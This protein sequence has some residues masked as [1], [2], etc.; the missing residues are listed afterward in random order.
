MTAAPTPLRARIEAAEVVKPE[1]P[2]FSATPFT[3][4]NPATIPPR[5]W[6]YGR[7]LLGASVTAMVAPGGVGKSTFVAGMALAMVTGIE[8]HNRKVWLGAKRVW[9]WNLE[10]PLDELNRSIGAAMLHFGITETDIEGRLFVDTAMD[11]Q[12]L[13]TATML[14][15]EVNVIAPVYDAIVAAIRERNIDGLIIDP[16]VSSHK[17]DENSNTA[18]DAITKEWVRVAAATGCCIVLVHHTSKAGSGEVTAMSGRGAVAMINACRSVLVFNRMD[19]ADASKLGIEE[20]EMWRYFCVHDDKHNRAPAEKAEWFR[21]ESVGLGNGTTDLP[22][23]MMGVARPWSPPD[24]FENIS[25]DHLR[26]VQSI[27]SS[28]L[29]RDSSQSPEWAGFAV[30]KVL[31]LEIASDADKPRFERAADKRQAAQ[32]LSTWI[33]NGALKVEE[34]PHPETRKTVKFVKVGL[35]CVDG[36][37]PPRAGGAEQGGAPARKNCSTTTTPPKGWVG[38]AVVLDEGTKVER[39]KAILAPGENEDDP[40]PGWE[41]VK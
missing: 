38:G 30:A 4:R 28:G 14:H 37:A 6:K 40:I 31:G 22:E 21:L 15:G 8:I 39:S 19:K 18:I 26:K 23:D 33:R 5:D 17:A 24:P 27:L 29:W 9:I 13:C 34:G 7:W 3:W 16:F 20:D 35:A 41:H 2:A 10:D 25:P 11:G 36:V 1:G 12:K 32:L